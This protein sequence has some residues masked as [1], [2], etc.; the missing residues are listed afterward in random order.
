M[1]GPPPTSPIPPIPTGQTAAGKR[2]ASA[3]TYYES[4]AGTSSTH[5][6]SSSR[7]TLNSQTLIAAV[8]AGNSNTISPPLPQHVLGRITEL[9]PRYI[10]LRHEEK[11]LLEAE[12]ALNNVQNRLSATQEYL[13]QYEKE[14]SELDTR[15][16]YEKKARS[17][18]F[19]GSRTKHNLAIVDLEE[20]RATVDLSISALKR[21]LT[22]LQ[23]QRH[24]LRDVARK[25]K[26]IRDELQNIFTE[27]FEGFPSE[28][29]EERELDLKVTDLA[30]RVQSLKD[31]HDLTTRIHTLLVEI[32]TGLD[33]I[34]I[35]IIKGKLKPS[36]VVEQVM[37][38]TRV[39]EVVQRLRPGIM[40]PFKGIDPSD[41][42]LTDRR[43]NSTEANLTLIQSTLATL[44]EELAW[45]STG[46]AK[47]LE[48]TKQNHRAA[49]QQLERERHRVVLLAVAVKQQQLRESASTLKQSQLELSGDDLSGSTHHSQSIVDVASYRGSYSSFDTPLGDVA[50][51]NEGF[52]LVAAQPILNE[53]DS[54]A[55]IRRSSWLNGSRFGSPSSSPTSIPSPL[56]PI[57][58]PPLVHRWPV[59]PISPRTAQTSRFNGIEG[60][61]R[62]SI[63]TKPS[64][65]LFERTVYIQGISGD[66]VAVATGEL[67]AWA[68]RAEN[69]PKGVA[70]PARKSFAVRRGGKY[71]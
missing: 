48:T 2:S 59:S 57:L 11:S 14:I 32:H 71:W 39:F 29:P 15:I 3:T 25:T 65:P 9:A 18:T 62:E 8:R 6:V 31:Q 53:R 27:L 4:H 58:S 36:K 52:G 33:C 54:I 17:R 67:P 49:T 69:V 55:S 64:M 61:R 68:R 5:S 40:D 63:A 13:M 70:M 21:D 24:D 47:E 22:S 45:E 35:S 30:I 38:T 41:S 12:K 46:F 43:I 26:Q 50:S 10:Q 60:L 37:D 51:N 7:R 23:L 20:R 34:H 28:F 42:H 1:H 56:L 19:L 16:E 66:P 44:I